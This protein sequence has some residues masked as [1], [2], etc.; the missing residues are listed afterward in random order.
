MGWLARLLV[1]LP[2]VHCL[3]VSLAVPH[4]VL[5]RGQEAETPAFPQVPCLEEPLAM[6][7]FPHL[8][9]YRGLEAVAAEILLPL[10]VIKKV[11]QYMFA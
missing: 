7:H 10:L 8:V 9:L 11:N 6:S 2:Q 3:V 5:C 1:G 4:H